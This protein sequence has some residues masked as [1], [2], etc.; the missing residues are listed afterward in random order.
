MTDNR[1]FVEWKNTSLDT[2]S[3]RVQ[4]PVP[5][6]RSDFLDFNAGTSPNDGEYIN[7]FIARFDNSDLNQ[8]YFKFTGDWTPRRSGT[9][10]R[11]I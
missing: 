2:L 8:N 10:V 5:Q 9:L 11:G 6:R 7:R 4:V 1:F 3:T